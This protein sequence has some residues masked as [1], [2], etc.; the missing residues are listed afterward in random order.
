MGYRS[1]DQVFNPAGST[2]D[3]TSWPRIENDHRYTGGHYILELPTHRLV[4]R[5]HRVSLNQLEVL[6][7]LDFRMRQ[8]MRIVKTGD[9]TNNV[10]WEWQKDSPYNE[11]PCITRIGR[12]E[13]YPIINVHTMVVE[14][15]IAGVGDCFLYPKG[16]KEPIPEH[17]GSFPVPEEVLKY[18]TSKFY[19]NLRRAERFPWNS[20]LALDLS[21]LVDPGDQS[22]DVNEII[23]R[24]TCVR[25]MVPY[26][27][28]PGIAEHFLH[29]YTMKSFRHAV[30]LYMGEDI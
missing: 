3:E 10:V 12:Y 19:T 11:F 2:I 13:T 16:C 24:C 17:E 7:S 4:G 25:D 9:E 20:D 1:M 21:H 23:K 6:I 27:L 28:S 5:I 29:M 22:L 18:R 15:S 30:K 26:F 8:V 14:I